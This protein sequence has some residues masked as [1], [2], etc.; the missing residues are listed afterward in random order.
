MQVY[1]HVQILMEPPKYESHSYGW[2]YLKF[3]NQ[4]KQLYSSGC[5]WKF[6]NQLKHSYDAGIRALSLFR[7]NKAAAQLV[8]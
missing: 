3:I 2:L 8:L 5:I 1:M 7:P 6:I 4:L